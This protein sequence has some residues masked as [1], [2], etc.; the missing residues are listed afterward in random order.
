MPQSLTEQFVQDRQ[1]ILGV[2]RKTVDNA[3]YRVVG[4]RYAARSK[5][6]PHGRHA[7]R[8]GIPRDPPPDVPGVVVVVSWLA[9]A[10][11]MHE[12][13]FQDPCGFRI[14]QELAATHFS[15]LAARPR[16]GPPGARLQARSHAGDR[17]LSCGS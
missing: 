5:R 1:Y 4:D 14:A 9:V 16:N 8:A 11:P 15:F 6:L 7:E 3:A 12:R 13:L 17:R 2:S 10:V